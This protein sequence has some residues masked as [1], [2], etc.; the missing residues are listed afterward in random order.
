MDPA[1]DSLIER[2]K[3]HERRTKLAQGYIAFVAAL[4]VAAIARSND[5]PHAWIVI[6]LLA[7][8]QPSLVAFILLDH[9]VRAH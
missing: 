7:V 3:V 1:S 9:L 8:S 6:S 4:L 5:Y 2:E